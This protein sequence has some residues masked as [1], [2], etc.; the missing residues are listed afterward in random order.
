MRSRLDWRGPRQGANAPRHSLLLSGHRIIPPPLPLW[1]VEGAASRSPERSL[2]RSQVLDCIS[3]MRAAIYT[4]ISDDRAGDAGGVNRQEEDCRSLAENRDL[5]ITQVFTDNDTS[6][7][8]GKKRP[9]YEALMVSLAAGEIDAILAWHPDRLHRFPREL[10][11]FIDA[12]DK[13]GAAVATVQAGEYDLSSASG[14]MQARIVGAVARHESEQKSERVRRKAA[15]IALEGRVGGGGTRPFGYE[16]DRVTIR[17]SEAECVREATA[18][19]LAGETVGRVAIDWNERGVKTVTGKPWSTTVL[20]RMLIGPRIAGLREHRGEVVAE[21]VWS[22]IIDRPTWERVHTL[23]TDPKRRTNKGGPARKYL[24]SSFLE[25]GICGLAVFARPKSDGT[26]RYVCAKTPKVRDA[27]GKIA[28]VAEPLEKLVGKAIRT[29]LNSRDLTLALSG[30]TDKEAR[31][32]ALDL[33]AQLAAD[34]DALAELASDYYSDR[35]IGRREFLTARSRLDDRVRGIRRQLGAI[36][37]RGAVI[38]LPSGAEAV[39]EAWQ[40]RGLDWRRA[41]VAAVIDR[42]IIRP[43]SKPGSHYFEPDRVE[44]IWRA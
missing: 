15:Q 25:C 40:A 29:V 12:V 22:G 3:G 18:R 14:R 35:L 9:G 39:S 43:A 34:E 38:D 5:T 32:T 16:A 4:R 7:Y 17:E 1:W 42:I 33:T 31:Q 24:L 8:T 27:C 13:A 10:E 28:I 19:I 23:L 11:S 21:A 37:T 6:A 44:V 36:Q 2:S 30:V 26:R 41:L 20:K